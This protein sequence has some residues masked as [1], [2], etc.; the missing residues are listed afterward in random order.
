MSFCHTQMSNAE[1]ISCSQHD[2]FDSVSFSFDF[3]LKVHSQHSNAKK[4]MELRGWIECSLGTEVSTHWTHLI[5]KVLIYNIGKYT[6]SMVSN[7][8]ANGVSNVVILF[9]ES[10]YI[11]TMP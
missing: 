3:I 2:F 4:S 9:G 8:Y 1:S 6:R 5:P 7:S 10:L 11:Q